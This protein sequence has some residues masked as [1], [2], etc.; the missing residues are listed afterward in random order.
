MKK[1][2]VVRGLRKIADATAKKFSRRGATVKNSYAEQGADIIEKQ[3]ERIEALEEVL[4]RLGFCPAC[5]S[6]PDHDLVEP[7]SSCACGTGEDYLACPLQKIKYLHTQ[8]TDLKE[9]LTIISVAANRNMELEYLTSLVNKVY[10]KENQPVTTN[11]RN[12]ER[13]QRTM[14]IIDEIVYED[15]WKTI[16]VHRLAMN[17]ISMFGF[18]N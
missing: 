7:F 8:N 9:K 15:I 4:K 18:E 5:M 1:E 12:A 2:T 10:P 11:S 16:L 13:D 14:E 6:I 17:T 3:S